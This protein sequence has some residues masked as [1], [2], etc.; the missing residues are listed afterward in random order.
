LNEKNLLEKFGAHS[1]FAV[2]AD[3]TVVSRNGV[4]TNCGGIAKIHAR[5]TVNPAGGITFRVSEQDGEHDEGYGV[6]VPGAAVPPEFRAAIFK[7]AQ[8]AFEQ[9][10][11]RIGICFELLDAFVHMVDARESRF[12]AAGW[13]AI[14]GW[15]EEYAKNAGQII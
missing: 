8:E 3:G 15:L 6:A 11:P 7:G 13:I 10:D 1:Q 9:S 12:Q 4:Q 2:L 14:T 5:I